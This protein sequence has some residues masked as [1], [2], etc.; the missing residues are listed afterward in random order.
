M[1]GSLEYSVC[2]AL[3]SR[4]ETLKGGAGAD[5]ALCHIQVCGI[6]FFNFGISHCRFQQLFKAFTRRFGRVA[7]RVVLDRDGADVV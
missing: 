5:K 3:V 7:E 2:A 4:L 1:A 6:H